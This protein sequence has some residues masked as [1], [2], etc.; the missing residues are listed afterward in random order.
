MEPLSPRRELFVAEYLK[1]FNATRAYKA[2]GYKA[3][4]NSAVAAAS[5]LLTFDEINARIQQKMAELSERA[6]L[7]QEWIVERL[8]EN[9]ER[10]MQAE[11]VRDADGNIVGEYHYQGAV[12]N[13]AYELLGRHIGMWPDKRQLTGADG[14]PIRIAS[15]KDMNSD[16]I[17]REIAETEAAI[18]ALGTSEGGTE[19]GA[20]ANESA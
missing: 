5:R 7:T 17:A 1:D 10:A 15:A 16:D 13:R 14:G 18:A 9:A 8:R 6:E 2:A 12:A 20:G 4:G 11:P 19:E 3:Q